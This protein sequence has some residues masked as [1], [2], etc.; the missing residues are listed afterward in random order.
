MSQQAITQLLEARLGNW[1]ETQGLQV[2][3]DNI[4]FTPPDGIYLESQVMP[5]TTTA[6][7]LSRKAKVF[8]GVYQINVIAPAG[9]GKSAGGSI[10]EQL[11][12]LFPENQEM[13]DGELTC[14][15]N[16]APSAFA[17]I[18]TDTSYTI[19]VS[20]SYRADVS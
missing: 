10:A 6:I 7:D 20:M 12:D 9:T 11:I 3:F 1:A 19:P 14:F 4:E 17:G 2:A 16:S 8:R 13:S 5:A 18:S 15:I